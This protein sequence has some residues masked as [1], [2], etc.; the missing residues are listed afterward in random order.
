MAPAQPLVTLGLGQITYQLESA[1]STNNLPKINVRN[2]VIE[3]AQSLKK[4][5]AGKYHNYGIKD[6]IA[7]IA[8]TKRN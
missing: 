2:S 3:C 5:N 8:A 4:E 1:M 7:S 6:C